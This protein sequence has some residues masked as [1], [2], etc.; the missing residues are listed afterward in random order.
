[1]EANNF[2]L[3]MVQIVFAGNEHYSFIHSEIKMFTQNI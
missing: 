3:E 1:M 2:N